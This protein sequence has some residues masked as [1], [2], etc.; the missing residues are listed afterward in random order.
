MKE[1]CITII[2]QQS[3]STS[4]NNYIL[5]IIYLNYD[6]DNDMFEN[7]IENLTGF[8]M[9]R[10]GYYII[11]LVDDIIVPDI[12]VPDPNDQN[13]NDQDPIP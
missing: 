13:P 9:N 4:N 5:N 2:K 8:I 3:I 11:P 10:I 1:Q 12:I 6:D 7:I